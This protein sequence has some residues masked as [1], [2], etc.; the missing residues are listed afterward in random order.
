MRRR[1]EVEDSITVNNSTLLRFQASPSLQVGASIPEIPLPPLL[2]LDLKN[3]HEEVHGDRRR[4]LEKR[5]NIHPL[6]SLDLLLYFAP[7]HLLRRSLEIF[8]SLELISTDWLTPE[9]RIPRRIR[10][11]I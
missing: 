7:L 10:E 11:L 9:R 5:G 6:P 2:R 8:H 3:S 1:E 4:S